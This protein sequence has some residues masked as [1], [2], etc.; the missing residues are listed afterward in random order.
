ME[1]STAIVIGAG[2]VGLAHAR[3][4]SLK[5]YL[6]TVFE[7]H[8]QAIGASIRNFGMIWPVGQPDGVLYDRACR[9]REIWK[10][11]CTR[12]NIW[13]DE[14]GSLHIATHT[15][16]VTAM[17]EIAALYETSRNM[18]W[19]DKK[20]ALQ[21]TDYA[22]P[23]NTLGALW[24]P[25]EMIVEARE[26]IPALAKELEEQYGVS[27]HFSTAIS[28]VEGGKVWSGNRTWQADLI[29]IC[30]GVDF[31]TLFPEKFA[32]LAIT[33][34]KL[35]MMRLQSLPEG[36]KMGAALCGGLSLIHYKGF[37][38]SD[39]LQDLKQR[40]QSEMSEY[41]AWGIHVM[42]C[43]NPYGEITV[44]DTHEYGLHLNP[45]DKNHLNQLVLHYLSRFTALDKYPVVQT[46]N[47]I[48][49]KMTNGQTEYIE[50]V[51]DQLYFV[52]GLGG[53]G[54]TLSFGLADEVVG[55]I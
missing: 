4:L 55:R 20:E 12:A 5:G 24:S 14:V 39:A 52:N 47:G 15:D 6:V 31:E 3:A 42:A 25:S 18:L 17:Q 22:N 30:S 11:I 38:V 32:A 1:R 13:H 50:K 37:E 41:L 54:M 33:K 7:R 29:F 23:A 44:G 9:S 36:K 2:V 34:C 53:A 19:L 40:Y 10:S 46:W 49:A 16:E 35:Q 21:K 51:N 27:F 28:R 43:Q 26:A 45:F 8:P 48:Y